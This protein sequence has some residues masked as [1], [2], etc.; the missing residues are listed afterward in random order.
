[1]PRGVARERLLQLAAVA[2]QLSKIM[3]SEAALAWLYEPNPLLKNAR[4][5]DLIS[6]GRHEEVL[7]LI[8]AIA[9]GAF[10]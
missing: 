6:Q 4:P 8:D 5:I 2:A 1:M 10:V 9:D 3:A 7:D